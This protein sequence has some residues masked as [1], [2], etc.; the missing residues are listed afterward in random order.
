MNI[1]AEESHQLSGC[2][3]AQRRRLIDRYSD[4][5]LPPLKPDS[6][7]SGIPSMEMTSTN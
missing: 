2:S 3:A 4:S 7:K 1:D 5:G 6:S